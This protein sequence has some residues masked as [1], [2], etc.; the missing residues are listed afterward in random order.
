MNIFFPLTMHEMVVRITIYKFAVTTQTTYIQVT[1]D[2]CWTNI[3]PGQ[4]IMLAGYE[5]CVKSMAHVVPLDMK[6][7][8]FHF[9]KWQ[10]YP[11]ISKKSMYFQS[12][13]AELRRW[14]NIV[15]LL[16]KCLVL[17]G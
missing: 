5:T 12:I 2:Q 11:F 9:A 10:M 13:Y 16:Y 15:Q 1:T 3:E 4:R 7:C 6:G 14:T 8:I 17:A